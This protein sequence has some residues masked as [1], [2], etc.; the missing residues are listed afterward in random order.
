[1][2]SLVALTTLCLL[3][4]LCGCGA[5]S[6]LPTAQDGKQTVEGGASLPTEH[7]A[8]QFIRQDITKNNRPL[9]L[10]SFHKTDGQKSVVNGVEHYRLEYRA[11]IEFTEDCCW[12]G[13]GQGQEVNE[14]GKKVLLGKGFATLFAPFAA[15][16]DYN[17][18]KG[19]R[20]KTTDEVEFE[21]T[22]NGW[23]PSTYLY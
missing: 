4:V 16:K 6:S 21:K 10:V 9:K 5:S 23:R 8:E 2:K 14:E 3:V 19:Q 1:M 11:E 13:K 22:E 17:V 15:E 12:R 20:W 18:K 7:D